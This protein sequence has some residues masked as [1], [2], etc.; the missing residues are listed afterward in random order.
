MSKR[1]LVADDNALIRK[2]LCTIFEV[3][4]DYDLCAEASNGEEAIDL[5]K[6]HKPDLIILDF[7]MPVMNGVDAAL[8]LKRIMPHVPIILLTLHADTLGTQLMGA[9]SPFDLIVS[10]IDMVNIVKHVRLLIPV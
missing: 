9:N 8:E 2:M 10:K 4:E 5:A 1:I 6:K 7:S 3:E